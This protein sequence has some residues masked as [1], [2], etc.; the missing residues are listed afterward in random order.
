VEL[1]FEGKM[2]PKDIAPHLTHETEQPQGE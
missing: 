2:S 1:V